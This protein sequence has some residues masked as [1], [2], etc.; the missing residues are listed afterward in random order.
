M[1]AIIYGISLEIM[2]AT[3]FVNRSA[4]WNDIIANTFGCVMAFVFRE[5]INLNYRKRLEN[6]N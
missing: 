6:L 2:Q 1:L 4:D 3:V 5:K